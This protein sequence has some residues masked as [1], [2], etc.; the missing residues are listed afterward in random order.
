MEH[1]SEP[2]DHKPDVNEKLNIAIVGNM[3]VG[4]SSLFSRMCSQNTQS[5]NIPGNT[6]TIHAGNIKGSNIKVFDTPGIGSIFSPNEDERASR[7]I[8]LSQKGIYDINR[9]LIV[10][11]AKKMARAIAIA[12][13][14][15]EYN[16]PMAIDIN[17]IDEANTWG[18]DIDTKKLSERLGVKVFETVAREGIGVNK[19]LSNLHQMQHS[20][21][22]IEYP[23]WIEKFLGI[24]T[25]LLDHT[26]TSPRAIGLLLLAEDNDVEKY[27]QNKYGAGMLLQLKDLSGEYRKESPIPCNILLTNI[28][29][30]M[31]DQIVNEI[32][33]STPP[34]KSPFLY[35]FGDACTKLST[36]IPIA[37]GI[38]WL[39]YLFVG[40]FGATYLVDTINVK[41]FEN[42][43]IPLTERIVS[44]IENAFIKDMII[45]PDFGILPT[46][47]FLA[48]GLVMPVLFCFYVAFGFLEDSGYLSRLSVLL[49]RVFQKMGLNGKGVIPMVMGFSCVTMAILTTRM[50]D[51][52]KEKIIASFLLLLG[53][54]CAPLL[55][56]MFVI[57]NKMP[58]SATFTV[59]GF[60]FFQILIAGFL[61]NKILPGNKS[62]LFLEIPPMRL[63]KFFQI[64][65]LASLKT[66]FF[67]KEAI[68]VFITASIFIFLFDRMGG[69]TAL[70][71]LAEPII[72]GLMGLPEKSVQVFIKAII[73]RESGATEI[74]HL[75]GIYTNLQMVV[76]LLVMT[77]LSP[78]INATIVLFK[79]RGTKAA[80]FI[81]GSVMIYA[82][83]V[84]SVVNHT[85]HFLGITFA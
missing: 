32:Q 4:K 64:I 85:C 68:P 19:I 81:L 30:T 22:L 41:V 63:P 27:I 67:M 29:N 37:F 79:E 57:L 47:I 61:A 56:V 12:L 17:M 69:L 25:K 34:S 45:D 73:R 36:G 15:A 6:A 13:Q 60:I 66:Y 77:F 35:K 1:K 10:C 70:E 14:Y 83:L 43:L 18:I 31:A 74:E 28:Y 3:N 21:K 8:L 72:S 82:F 39:M 24:V 20:K 52:K 71:R 50:L 65:K 55:A 38:I 75:S 42:F 62:P 33:I 53:M 11:D 2:T 58:L 84:G 46:G 76:N 80:I 40:K 23:D 51:T 9:I 49:N 48:L 59:F 16:L 7:S 54:P 5:I 78:C 26:E 44:P